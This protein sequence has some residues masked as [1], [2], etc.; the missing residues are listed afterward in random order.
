MT[1][2]IAV[3]IVLICSGICSLVE[4]ALFSV[5]QIKVR[6]LAESRRPA[7]L[8]LSRVRENMRDPIAAVV[9]LTNISNI[10]GS[11]MVGGIAAEVLGSKWMGTFSGGL[12]F[13]F[14]IFAEI[15]PKTLGERHSV[16]ISLFCARPILLVAKLL[17]PLIWIVQ[18]ITSPVTKGESSQLTTSE[19]EIKLLASI[20]RNSGVLDSN[21]SELIR[22]SFKLDDLTARDIMTPRVAMTSLEGNRTLVEATHDIIA[23]QHTRIVIIG[24]TR[25]NVIGFCRK[26]ELLTRIVEQRGAAKLSDLATEI[27]RFPDHATAST[28]FDHFRKSRVPISIA[29]DEFGGVAGIVTLEDVLE[30]LTGEIVDETDHVVDMRESVRK[31]G[32]VSD[33][34]LGA[35][36]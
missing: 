7:A 27:P 6:Q 28:L 14:I 9:I 36:N 24:E 16:G 31:A 23:S 21:E 5:S 1:L 13:L 32:T 26:D 34:T 10:I 30:I 29:V 11:I 4:A 19:A 25:D 22:Q 8:A 2:A 15:I 33:P 17:R 12:T 35:T 18:V 20:G 3:L